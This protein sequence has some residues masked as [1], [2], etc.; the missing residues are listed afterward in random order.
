MESDTLFLGAGILV[1]AVLVIW[2]IKKVSV[3]SNE[4]RKLAELTAQLEHRVHRLSV[5]LSQEISRLNRVRDLTNNVYLACS[6]S[7]FLSSMAFKSPRAVVENI[8]NSSP[9]FTLED[10]AVIRITVNGSLVEMI[11]LGDVIDNA[12]LKSLIEKFRQNVT[13]LS[14]S[15]SLD[16]LSKQ[17]KKLARSAIALHKQV[18]MLLQETTGEKTYPFTA[19]SVKPLMKYL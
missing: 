1:N 9:G 15:A 7:S 5:G 3:Q 11:A 14:N 8:E 18:Y 17:D 19:P 16:E 13:D 4:T 2:S 6:K 10:S 12:E